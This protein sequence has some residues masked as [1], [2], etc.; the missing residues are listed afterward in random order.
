MRWMGKYENLTCDLLRYPVREENTCNTQRIWYDGFKMGVRNRMEV[1]NWMWLT[2]FSVQG[3]LFWIRQ[4]NYGSQR[5]HVISKHSKGCYFNTCAVH[6]LLFCNMTNKGTIISQII[7]LLLVSTLSRHP[8]RAC[9][10]YL[11]KLHKLHLKHL[12]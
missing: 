4:R 7:T 9:N 2:Q 10:Q 6:L 5:R 8:Q 3:G 12:C 1:A 11:A